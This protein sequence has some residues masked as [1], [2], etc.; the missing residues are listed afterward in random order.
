MH[1][2]SSYADGLS[3]EAKARYLDKIAVINGKDPLTSVLSEVLREHEDSDDIPPVDA[4]D[5][6]DWRLMI[7]LCVDGYKIVV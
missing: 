4:C 1:R 2:L 7:S 5:L 3:Q 6:R